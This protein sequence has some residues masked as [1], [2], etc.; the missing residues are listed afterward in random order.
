M[1][2]PQQRP[3]PGETIAFARTPGDE[4]AYP[5]VLVEDP[6]G[7]LYLWTHSVGLLPLT[8]EQEDVL[9]RDKARF[10]PIAPTPLPNDLAVRS[11]RVSL[12]RLRW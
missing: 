12:G 7:A 2:A 4:Q 1:S 9:L 3:Y 5:S 10:V 6:Y 11:P 8:K